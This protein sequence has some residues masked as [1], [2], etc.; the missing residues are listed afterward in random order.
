[1]E[2]HECR[3]G[4]TCICNVSALEPNEDCPIHGYPYPNKCE[5][6]GRFIKTKK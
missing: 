6:C 3:E 2:A 5:I 1:M 4:Q